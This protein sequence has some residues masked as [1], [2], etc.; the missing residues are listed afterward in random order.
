MIHFKDKV[1]SAL[2]KINDS[3]KREQKQEKIS[4]FVEQQGAIITLVDH[5]HS[6]Q[7]NEIQFRQMSK[8]AIAA[9]LKF[10]H[11][12]CIEFIQRQSGRASYEEWIREFH[13]ES[14]CASSGCLDHRYFVR[15]SDHRIIWNGYCDM[16]GYP[17]RKI[18]YTL[19]SED[20]EKSLY[21]DD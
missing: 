16:H 13:P 8:E 2:R 7:E 3:M 18:Q 15:D 11:E 6:E 4:N 5:I 9:C 20:E 17:E 1:S 14:V 12:H 10:I 21:Y 19:P